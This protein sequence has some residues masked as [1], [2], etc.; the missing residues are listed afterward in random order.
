MTRLAAIVA[1]TLGLASPSQATEPLPFELAVAEAHG[2]DAMPAGLVLRADVTVMFG[3]GTAVDGADFTWTADAARTRMEAKDGS[4]AVFDGTTA[5]AEPAGNAMTRFHLL[6]WPYFA[7]LPFKLDDGGTQLEHVEPATTRPAEGGNPLSRAKLTFGDGVGDS[8]DDW[9]I[10][11]ANDDGRLG[12]AAYTVTY[13]KTVEQAEAEPHAIVYDG[14]VDVPLPDGTPSGVVI[15]TA[16]TFHN[17]SEADGV[18]PAVIGTATLD[19][20]RFVP[21][22]DGMFEAPTG[23]VEVEAP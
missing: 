9:Y 11:Y 10:L 15:S 1:L 12:A 20:L 19:N 6:T 14:F 18:D 5:W 17:W 16:W 2:R 21:M 22:E 23:A 4:L 3:G 7:M 13:G 8:P